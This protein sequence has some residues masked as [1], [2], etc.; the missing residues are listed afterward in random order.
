MTLWKNLPLNAV[1]SLPPD[2]LTVPVGWMLV[3]RWQ[4]TVLKFDGE[5]PCW[6]PDTHSYTHHTHTVP[7]RA[8]L[9]LLPTVKQQ[10]SKLFIDET[11]VF[12]TDLLFPSSC[13]KNCSSSLSQD[14]WLT[15]LQDQKPC[16]LTTEEG[17]TSRRGLTDINQFHLLLLKYNTALKC[18]HTWCNKCPLNVLAHRY[19]D[20]DRTNYNRE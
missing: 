5:V 6:H 16:I 12:F 7:L 3:M 9:D 11:A 13:L 15:F 17:Q 2:S 8:V 18:N 19:F 1:L 4:I 10:C 14:S 20:F